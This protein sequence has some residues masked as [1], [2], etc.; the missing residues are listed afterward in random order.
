[1]IISS[2]LSAL[3]CIA[4]LTQARGASETILEMPSDWDTLYVVLLTEG[5]EYDDN[6]APAETQATMYQHIQYQ[7]GLQDSGKA[8]AGGGFGEASDGMIGLTL[9]RAESLEEAQRIAN[10]DPAV[11]AGRF[12]ALV[13]TWYIPD[14]R[15]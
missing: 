7:L 11:V 15:L 6:S 10:D 14:G 4:I 2:G 1:M 12:H 5:P 8:I 9:L 13:K 3:L